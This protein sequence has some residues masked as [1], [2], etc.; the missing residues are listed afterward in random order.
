MS[1]SAAWS[2]LVNQYTDMVNV[3]VWVAGGGGG[4][5]GEGG[6]KIIFSI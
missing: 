1:V 5:G 4:G 6:F 3:W 2:I